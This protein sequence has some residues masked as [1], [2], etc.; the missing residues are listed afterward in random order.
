MI[1]PQ[2]LQGLT[3]DEFERLCLAGL[4]NKYGAGKRPFR[5]RGELT[6]PDQGVDIEG[7][8]R[9]GWTG[10]QC[11]TGP[12]TPDVVKEALKAIAGYREKLV[13]FLIL[14]AKSPTPSAL[15][16]FKKLKSTVTTALGPVPDVFMWGPEELFAEF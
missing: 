11:K 4:N 10:G 13:R 12:V 5:R 7:E 3:P 6:H 2:R 9:V 14:S 8:T 15:D 1:N 16:T